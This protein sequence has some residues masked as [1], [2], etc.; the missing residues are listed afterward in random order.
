MCVHIIYTY[1]YIYMFVYFFIYVYVCLH[2]PFPCFVPGLQALL[3]ITHAEKSDRTEVVPQGATVGASKLLK[4]FRAC[5]TSVS[6]G[7]SGNELAKMMFIEIL[8]SLVWILWLQTRST[9]P[10]YLQSDFWD[11]PAGGV[12]L[13]PAPEARLPPWSKP[14]T[15]RALSVSG[16]FDIL[17][18]EVLGGSHSPDA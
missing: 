18:I 3:S 14:L 5:K 16:D 11:G 8:S 12:A 15:L 17:G 1:I 2:G 7:M 6:Q 10:A 4:C 9:K 13:C